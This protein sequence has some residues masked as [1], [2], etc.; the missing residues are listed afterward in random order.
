MTEE[1]TTTDTA[2]TAD[3]GGAPQSD[4][5][6]SDADAT[7]TRSAG[8]D[9]APEATQDAGAASASSGG[10]KSWRGR[11]RAAKPE[12]SGRSAAAAT[13]TEEQDRATEQDGTEE[14]GEAAP[15][16]QTR[17]KQPKQPK[18]K[19][20]KKVA[21]KKRR[22]PG[23]GMGVGQVRTLVARIV[24]VVC[25]VFALLLALTALFIALKA[26]AD[27]DAVRFIVDAA[28]KV[29]LGVFDLRN[30][31]KDFDTGEGPSTD[32]K[33]ALFNYGIG[34]VVW[35]IIGR[36]GDRVIRP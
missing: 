13:A 34:A 12:K 4:P 32:T 1:K 10:K 25:L 36:I 22:T 20:E 11:A 6:A 17:Q 27:N 26:N 7:A 9:G 28:D 2:D 15:E 23:H 3:T 19:R 31:I 8:S 5:V 16:K 33:T 29:D 24:W 18:Q 30:P 35:L 21:E 14:A